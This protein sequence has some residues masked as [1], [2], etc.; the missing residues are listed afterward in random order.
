MASPATYAPTAAWSAWVRSTAADWRTAAGTPAG[1]PGLPARPERRGGG[2]VAGGQAGLTGASG[3]CLA[4][5]ETEREESCPGGQLADQR[6]HAGTRAGIRPA[7]RLVVREVG[8]T[9]RGAD[10]AGAELLVRGGAGVH[11][12][13]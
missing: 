6:H 11:D 5:A 3:G 9:V 10:V 13:A 4:V 12:P 2:V 7:H 1:S 8:P